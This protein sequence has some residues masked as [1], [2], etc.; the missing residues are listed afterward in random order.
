[1]QDLA[2]LA[3]AWEVPVSGTQPFPCSSALSE[4]WR[5]LGA[6]P[7]LKARNKLGKRHSV[8]GSVSTDSISFL[9]CLHLLDD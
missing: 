4:P 8:A 1:M 3:V 2:A 9:L 5:A 6:E 7:A